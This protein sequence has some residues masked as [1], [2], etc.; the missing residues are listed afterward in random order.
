[1]PLT[2]AWTQQHP[3]S[4]LLLQ[5]C[6]RHPGAQHHQLRGTMKNKTVVTSWGQSVPTNVGSQCDMHLFS[7]HAQ[8]PLCLSQDKLHFGKLFKNKKAHSFRFLCKKKTLQYSLCV[9]RAL[10]AARNSLRMG[11]EDFCD[12][13]DFSKGFINNCM[14]KQVQCTAQISTQTQRVNHF[15]NHYGFR[16]STCIYLQIWQQRTSGG[17]KL[18]FNLKI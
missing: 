13:P 2:A 9:L 17:I 12:E 14:I 15:K 1:M 11:R 5:W 7:L 8:Y 10:K 4:L 18:L 16:F 3:C 6:H